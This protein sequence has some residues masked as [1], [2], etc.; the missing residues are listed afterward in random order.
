MVDLADMFQRAHRELPGTQLRREETMEVLEIPGVRGIAWRWLTTGKTLQFFPRVRKDANV[1]WTGGFF[2]VKQRGIEWRFRDPDHHL[3]QLF[4]YVGCSDCSSLPDDLVWSWISDAYQYVSELVG[5]GRARS[6]ESVAQ[7]ATAG[8]LS[9]LAVS[10]TAA[11]PP[12]NATSF[13]IGSVPDAVSD[14][15][16]GAVQ[17]VPQ[18]CFLDVN[19]NPLTQGVPN[20]DGLI[21]EALDRRG[22]EIATNYRPFTDAL[23]N[24]DIAVPAQ[25]LLVEIE[26]GRLPRLELDLLKIASACLQT[27]DRWQYGALI[28][29][30]TFIELALAGRQSPYRYL[31]RLE[32]VVRPI[33]QASQ[34]KG[35]LVIGYVDPRN[36]Q[37]QPHYDSGRGSGGPEQVSDLETL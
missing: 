25:K 20:L 28:V 37:L 27:P 4:S 26:K 17:S 34:L 5:R 14:A 18:T 13:V 16:L 7:R 9:D 8:R 19:G 33:L 12:S 30:A 23:F 35:L 31:Q 32:P 22:W 1:T 24:V 2:S 15:L 10:S 29:P 6:P 3:R 11:K 36:S 21:C